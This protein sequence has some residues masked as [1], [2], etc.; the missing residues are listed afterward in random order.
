M[1]EIKKLPVRLCLYPPLKSQG[2]FRVGAPHRNSALERPASV[3]DKTDGKL[4]EEFPVRQAC[5]HVGTSPGTAPAEALPSV[6]LPGGGGCLCRGTV[7]GGR[8]WPRARCEW[9]SVSLLI[10][11]DPLTSFSTI[12]LRYLSR[13]LLRIGW[14]RR[15]VVLLVP[16][17]QVPKGSTGKRLLLALGFVLSCSSGVGITPVLLKISKKPLGK[18]GLQNYQSSP[19]FT[20]PSEHKEAVETLDWYLQEVNRLMRTKKVEQSTGRA[21]FSVLSLPCCLSQRFSTGRAC[22]LGPGGMRAWLC[23]D[24]SSHH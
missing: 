9:G 23:G 14:N 20:L 12:D 3:R 6:T 2:I 15:L 21:I 8:R 22:T 10:L 13:T 17:G 7:E 5:G 24:G 16:L 4:N 19:F 11:R 18:S 1:V